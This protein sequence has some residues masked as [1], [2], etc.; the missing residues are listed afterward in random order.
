[1]ETLL[2]MCSSDTVVCTVYCLINSCYMPL[3]I[4]SGI[5][6][7]VIVDERYIESEDD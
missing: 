1:M 3:V 5:Y 6:D 4:I 7:V 2:G